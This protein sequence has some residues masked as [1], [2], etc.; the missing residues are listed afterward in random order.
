MPSA[1][2]AL[3]ASV[4]WGLTYALDEKILRSLPPLTLLFLDSVLAAAIV[5]PFVLAV[6]GLAPLRSVLSGGFR[7]QLP[8][9]LLTVVLVT[10]ANFLVLWGIGGSGAVAVSMIEISYPFFVAI[11]SWWLFGQASPLGVWAGGGLVTSGV[12]LVLRCAR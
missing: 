8:L 10:A 3:A 2:A 4:L 5:F 7:G 6:D 1:L 9:V 12:L 11:F